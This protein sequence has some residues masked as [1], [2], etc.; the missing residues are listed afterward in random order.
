MREKRDEAKYRT[1]YGRRMQILEPCF[2]DIR[3][4]KGMD[5]FS[6]RTKIKVTIQWLLYC[7]VP[8]IGKSIPGI[9]VESMG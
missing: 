2:L 1:V 8:N 9:A 7:I 4:C 6:L 5:R 3:Y